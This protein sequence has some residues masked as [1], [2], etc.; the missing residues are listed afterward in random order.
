MP[1]RTR[2]DVNAALSTDLESIEQRQQQTA[3]ESDP[4]MNTSVT[5]RSSTVNRLDKHIF[6]K[7]LAGDRGFNRSRV[8]Q[9]LLDD[10]LA[11][12]EL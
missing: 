12:L 2:E 11:K 3:G 6:E 8:M 4:L 10:Y 1:K 9:A 7:K 5:L